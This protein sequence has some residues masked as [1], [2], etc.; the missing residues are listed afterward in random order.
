MTA[1]YKSNNISYMIV[2]NMCNTWMVKYWP[3]PSA[4]PQWPSCPVPEPPACAEVVPQLL[5]HDP[6]HRYSWPMPSL[7]HA[8]W[9]RQRPCWKRVLPGPLPSGHGTGPAHPADHATCNRD[10]R[11]IMRIQLGE[12]ALEESNHSLMARMFTGSLQSGTQQ[13]WSQ[14]M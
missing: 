12:A 3:V 13:T 14:H 5:G 11:V 8:D 10:T 2:S 1:N 9:Y 7:P 6:H 4:C